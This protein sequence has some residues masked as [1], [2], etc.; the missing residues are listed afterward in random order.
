MTYKEFKEEIENT[1]LTSEEFYNYLLTKETQVKVKSFY[2][3]YLKEDIDLEE[4]AKRYDKTEYYL[5]TREQENERK[6][7]YNENAISQYL[8][9]VSSIKRITNEERIELLKEIRE[10]REELNKENITRSNIVEDLKKYN[11]KMKYFTKDEVN[12]KIIELKKIDKDSETINK[13]QKYNKYEEKVESFMQYNLR[14][15]IK[16]A[17]LV[18]LR[19]PTGCLD[20]GDL[21]QEGNMGLRRAIE[22]FELEK[23]IKFSTYAYYWIRQAIGR[24]IGNDSKMIRIPIHVYD[25]YIKVVRKERELQEEFDK[26]PTEEEVASSLGITLEK[27]RTIKKCS[28]DIVSL[29]APVKNDDD[30]DTSFGDFIADTTNDIEKQI[31]DFSNREQADKMLNIGYLSLKERLVLVLRY[32]FDFDQYISYEDFEF[33]LEKEYDKKFIKKLYIKLC[34]NSAAF[35]LDQIGKIFNVTRERVRQIEAKALRKIRVKF[36]CNKVKIK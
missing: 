11:I 20:I 23:N 29:D 19:R 6:E 2:E 14:L 34:N 17:R 31:D 18:S 5:E 1:L 21:I 24:A 7:F 26:Q 10:I 4:E 3:K 28:Q 36:H 8:N 12:K 33:M 32:G 13:L 35:T 15:V 25:E 30:S 16:V 22:D 9:Y 27:L